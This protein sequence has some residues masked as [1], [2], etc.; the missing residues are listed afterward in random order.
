MSDTI[1]YLLHETEIPKD[2]YNMIT[3]LPEPPPVVLHPGIHEPIGPDDLA[4]LS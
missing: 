1:K 3:D 2:W 4:P